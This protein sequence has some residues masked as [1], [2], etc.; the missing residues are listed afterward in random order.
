M[1]AS[2]FAALLLARRIGQGK[3]QGRCP[4]HADRSPSLSV[5]EGQDGRVLVHCFAGCALTQI[6]AALRLTP[7]RF[8]PWN[9][10]LSSKGPVTRLRGGYA[11]C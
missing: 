11:K 1:T 7:S 8:I 10:A 4:A 3:W 2:D 6:L 9:T 5:A